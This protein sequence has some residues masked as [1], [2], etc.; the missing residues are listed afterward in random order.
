LSEDDEILAPARGFVNRSPHCYNSPCLSAG[1]AHGHVPGPVD[2]GCRP[3]HSL[4]APDGPGLAPG[5]RVGGKPKGRSQA[6]R[7]YE[8]MM[9]AEPELDEEGVAAVTERVQQV[10][11][12]N[13]GEVIKVKQMGRRKLAYPIQRRREG[14][15]VLIHANMERETITEL[16]RNL[17]LSEDVFRHL[18][19]RLDEVQAPAGETAEES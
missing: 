10:I 16:E 11:T 17:R 4:S 7:T 8:L 19:V 5:R 14:H 3:F 1:R 15:Y 13:G 18:L 6:L 9:I 12:N 2:A